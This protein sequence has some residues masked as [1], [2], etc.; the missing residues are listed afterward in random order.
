MCHT[1]PLLPVE[2]DQPRQGKKKELPNQS[3][4][5]ASNIDVPL[6]IAIQ[7]MWLLRPNL[8]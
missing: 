3:T 2:T 8:C 4:T 1:R 7:L 6:H 5:N